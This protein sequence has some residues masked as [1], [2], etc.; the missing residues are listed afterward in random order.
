[1]NIEKIREAA[2]AYAI[3]NSEEGDFKPQTSFD[4]A[5]EKKLIE[6]IIKECASVVTDEY[7]VD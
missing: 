6:L 5:Y 1:M 7:D 3:I 4:K 2:F